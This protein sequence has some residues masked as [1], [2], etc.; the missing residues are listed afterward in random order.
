MA[1]TRPTDNEGVTVKSNGGSYRR[2]VS[3]AAFVLGG[4]VGA[5]FAP[6]HEMAGL[7]VGF[8]GAVTAQT[9]AYCTSSGAMRG[10]I[11]ALAAT[12]IGCGLMFVVARQ[13]PPEVVTACTKLIFVCGAMGT[14]LGFLIGRLRAS[15]LD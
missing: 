15:K 3:L 5:A 4:V 11:L 9:S 14:S 8:F 6:A 13:N 2:R 7:I 12:I 1:D 10:L